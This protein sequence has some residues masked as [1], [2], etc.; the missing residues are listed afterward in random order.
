MCQQISNAVTTMDTQVFNLSI[1]CV[2]VSLAVNGID[3]ARTAP[4]GRSLIS[5]PGTTGM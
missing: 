4:S 2:L 5:A 1:H 3:A